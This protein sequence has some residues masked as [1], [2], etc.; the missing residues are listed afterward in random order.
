[1]S[2]EDAHARLADAIA[3]SIST[4]IPSPFQVTAGNGAITVV[5]SAPR[6]LASTTMFSWLLEETDDLAVPADIATAA[7]AVLNSV[8]DYIIEALFGESWPSY[9]D[10]TRL[11]LPQ[12]AV[13][14][15]VLQMWYG[16]ATK[17][18]LRVPDVDLRL[19]GVA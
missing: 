12:A 1:M 13:I 10:D 16:T 11:P 14:D 5:S 4:V 8:Q 19:L 2:S 18:A 6:S 7:L 3:A 17:A 9:T 15:G